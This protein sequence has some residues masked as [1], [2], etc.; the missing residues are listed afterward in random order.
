M[1]ETSA[2]RPSDR[3]L[4]RRFREATE[5]T[6]IN[7]AQNLRTEAAKRQLEDGGPPA[8]EI[9]VDDGY[10]NTTFFRRLFKRSTG[11]APG[12]YRRMFQPLAAG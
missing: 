2:T 8:D 10:E 12:E 3:R 11:L 1:H 5:T 6:I 9:S 7:F 4:K